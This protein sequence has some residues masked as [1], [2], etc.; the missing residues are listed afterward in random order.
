MS[1]RA[2]LARELA[3][4]HRRI[5]EAARNA[6]KATLTTGLAAIMQTIGPFGPLF[7][8]RIGQPGI[9]LGLFEG[10]VTIT[11]AAAM[12]AAIVPIT[13]KLL[14]Y[15][16]LIL[17][18]LFVV[19]AAL[20]YLLSNT[21][22]FL[23]LALVAIGTIT[24]V[25]LGIF[26]P[27]AIGWGS[28]YTF[29][30]I[31]LATIVMVALDTLIWPSPL[32]PKL[33]ESIAADL[34]LTRG[35]F[36]SVGRRYLDR[37]STTLPAPLAKSRLAPALA[38]L[39]SVEEQMKP[40]AQRLAAL[41][42]AVMT[43][44]HVYLEVERLA[45]LADESV[46]DGV[47]QKHRE[48]IESSLRVLDA[49]LA[50]Q[51]DRILSGLSGIE[52]ST[53]WPSDLRVTIQHLSELSACASSGADESATP[54]TLNF[55]GFVGGLEAIA[56]L[57]DPRERPPSHTASEATEADNRLQAR[58]FVDPAR[59]RFSIK[60]GATIILGLLVGLTTQRADLQTILWSIVVAGQP[61][62]YGAVVRKTI[63]RLAGCITG[64]IAALAAMLLV[65]Q[66]FDSLAP[67]L[68]AIFA[69]TM[70]SSYISQ[71]SE[72][73]GYAG[74]QTGMTFLICYVGLAPSSDIYRPLW[75]FWGIVLG[76]LTTG[77]IYLFLWPEYASDKMMASL[78]ELTGNTLGFAREV[79]EHRITEG[80]ITA[81]QR[82]LSL[83]LLQLLNMAD[84]ARLEGHRGS[85]NSAAAVE[86]ADILIRIAYRFQTIARQRLLGSELI[87]PQNIREGYA[88]QE[89][90]YCF[91]LELELQKLKSAG[92]SRPSAPIAPASPR[93]E[94]MPR[95]LGVTSEPAT[96]TDLFEYFH[97][98]LVP[99]IE[100]YRRLPVLLRRLDTALS[101][102]AVG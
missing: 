60:L 53:Q 12:Q 38:L 40:T 26:E 82:R 17:A 63:L 5:V 49:A 39:N 90:K 80:R 41:L 25:Y 101:K 98:N 47:R 72:W 52:E 95:D 3:P 102:I 59:L 96:G 43:S 89:Q 69:V 20:G 4:T 87:L 8:F 83:N 97:T 37:V 44:E 84:Q 77:F 16:G 13:G 81:V 18:F 31:L 79:A 11:C 34:T 32:E 74:I 71:S 24:T 61:N 85:A 19:F 70:F 64:G 55:L 68:V 30:G 91:E 28:T 57:L 14:D 9:S 92:P 54:E 56:N 99:Q 51:I 42:A 66:N 27:G 2:F 94:P 21:R 76:V 48:E 67:Y 100:S 23:P 33:L 22:L 36:A 65:S 58:S 45:A 50:G 93:T 75:R 62:Q 35:R 29:D 1:L 46:S 86:A 78:I 15:P 88:M 6:T 7:A 10:A 73:L